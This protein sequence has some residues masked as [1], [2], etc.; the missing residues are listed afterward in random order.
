[1]DQDSIRL[2][3]R[4][5]LAAGDL[6]HDSISRFWGG[7]P[8]GEECDACEQVIRADQLVMEGISATTNQGLQLHVECLYL[9]DEERNA[10]GRH[11]D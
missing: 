7:P 1:M 5:K 3:I 8:D 11:N 4:R 2:L 9:W 10:P 6:P